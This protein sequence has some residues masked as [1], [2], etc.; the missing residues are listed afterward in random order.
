MSRNPKGTRYLADLK[1][2]ANLPLKLR[3]EAE[4]IVMFAYGP[5][6]LRTWAEAREFCVKQGMKPSTFKRIDSGLKRRNL[7]KPC[8]VHYGSREINPELQQC[9][10]QIAGDIDST[11]RYRLDHP[12]SSVGGVPSLDLLVRTFHNTMKRIKGNEPVFEGLPE[13]LKPWI[14]F[15]SEKRITA[16]T[17]VEIIEW[18]QWIRNWLATGAR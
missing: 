14:H 8:D 5:E 17:E 12:D 3:S 7:V 9:R 13:D 11:L 10:K 16:I 4:N 18:L 2:Y 15:E 6:K 1:T